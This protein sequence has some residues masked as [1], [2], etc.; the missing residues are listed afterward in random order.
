MENKIKD[1]VLLQVFNS[2]VDAI[3][4]VKL[5][6]SSDN[7]VFLHIDNEKVRIEVVKDTSGHVRNLNITDKEK[8]LEKYAYNNVIRIEYDEVAGDFELLRDLSTTTVYYNNKETNF[9]LIEFRNNVITRIIEEIEKGL[10]SINGIPY[11]F[12]EISST[13]PYRVSYNKGKIQF[14]IEILLTENNTCQLTTLFNDDAPEHDVITD[15]VFNT[16]SMINSYL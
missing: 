11:T 10:S 13:E 4:D 7:A 2:L 9:K 15:D 14:N 16:Q 12:N 5:I 6:E 3:S 8:I 1:R